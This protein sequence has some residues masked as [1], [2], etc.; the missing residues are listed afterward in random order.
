MPGED[1]Q[2]PHAP[3]HFLAGSGTFMVT[4][5]TYGKQ[6]WVSSRKRLRLLTECIHQHATKHGWR[7]A[8]WA[9]FSNHY[10]WIGQAPEDKGASGLADMIAATHRESAMFLNELDQTP[11]RQVWHNYYESTLS[12]QP[13][14]LARLHYVS[15]NPV[16]HGLVLKAE[17]YPWCSAGWLEKNST[18]AFRN[19]LASFKIDRL[20]ILDDF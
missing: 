18:T 9:V 11:G 7:L 17:D 14:Y 8:A 2:W 13:S 19:T 15:Q 5:A 6:H 10:H 16:K 20:R 12:F 4:G 1:F 3:P